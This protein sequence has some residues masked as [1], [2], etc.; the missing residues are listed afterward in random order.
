MITWFIWKPKKWSRAIASP[1]GFQEAFVHVKNRYSPNRIV[2][3]SGKPVRFNFIRE[4]QNACSEIVIFPDFQKSVTLPTGKN[5]IIELPPMD[6]GKYEF[7]CQMGIYRGIIISTK[8]I[9]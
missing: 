5:V 2:V 6:E 4:E 1:S 9:I 7:T 8:S 3:Q